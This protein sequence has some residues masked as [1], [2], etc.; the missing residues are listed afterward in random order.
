MKGGCHCGAVAYEVDRIE[1][2]I[3]HCH[4]TTCRKTHSA[5]YATTARVEKSRFRWLRGEDRVTAYESSPGKKRFF[6]AS[7]G[8][9]IVAARDGQPSVI[10]RVA[11]LDDDP[12]LRPQ[13]H[14]WRS[15]DVPWLA[16]DDSM[17][18]YDEWQPDRK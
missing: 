8:C 13:F 14:I 11:T 6:C 3:G 18:S 4:C 17:P 10:L 1:G 15:H 12:G 7:C 2:P 5:A 9:H 16:D